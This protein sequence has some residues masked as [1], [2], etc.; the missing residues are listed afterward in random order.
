MHIERYTG[1]FQR[2]RALGRW[3][4]RGKATPAG[5]ERKER[6][7]GHAPGPPPWRSRCALESHQRVRIRRGYRA[8]PASGASHSDDPSHPRAS[9]RSSNVLPNMPRFTATSSPDFREFGPNERWLRRQS[10]GYDTAS[11]WAIFW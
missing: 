5:N 6:M 2:L 4:D 1:E 9:S 3:C 7:L 8:S 11:I 10:S